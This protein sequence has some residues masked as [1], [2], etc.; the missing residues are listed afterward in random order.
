MIFDFLVLLYL[1]IGIIVGDYV[2]KKHEYR[3]G[4]DYAYPLSHL[5]LLVI[6]WLPFVFLSIAA[7]LLRRR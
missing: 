5:F 6:L 2:R 1:L 4:G 3:I 7:R